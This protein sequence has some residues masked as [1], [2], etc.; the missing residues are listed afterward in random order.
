M[1]KRSGKTRTG[2]WLVRRGRIVIARRVS[3]MGKI[4]SSSVL[5]VDIGLWDGSNARSL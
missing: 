4:G 1:R 5:D 2:L 3:A